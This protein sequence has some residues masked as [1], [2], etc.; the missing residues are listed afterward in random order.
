MDVICIWIFKRWDLVAVGYQII[1][2]WGI[3][4]Y[5]LSKEDF[6][7]TGLNQTDRLFPH[8]SLVQPSV[9]LVLG[10]NVVPSRITVPF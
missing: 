4:N 6:T 8:L 1:G 3:L 7:P 5:T 10:L 2:K 9:T